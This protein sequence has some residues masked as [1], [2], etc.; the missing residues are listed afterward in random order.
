M[1]YLVLILSWILFIVL[2]MDSIISNGITPDCL[3]NCFHYTVMHA[4]WPHLI[5]NTVALCLLW[6]PMRKIYIKKYDS[7]TRLFDLSTYFA[8][9]F[10]GLACAT[11]VPTVG[12]SGMV[13]FLLGALLMMHPTKRL[14]LNYLW[15]IAACAIQWYFGKTN[16]ALHIFA[17]VEGVAYICV[18]E[19]IYQ[20]K[21]G[22]GLFEPK[23][24]C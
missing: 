1:I 10:A 4:S 13:Y 17:F 11:D 7:D 19:F 6:F 23:E 14:A 22:T 2:P 3:Y 24:E 20:Y 9:V 18:R 15:I 12:M 16:V 21:N 8:A 5:I